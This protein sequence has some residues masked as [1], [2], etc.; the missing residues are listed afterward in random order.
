MA[1]ETMTGPRHPIVHK[2]PRSPLEHEPVQAPAVARWVG[3]GRGPRA[4]RACHD[5]SLCIEAISDRVHESSCRRA[6]TAGS[7]S[8]PTASCSADPAC[9]KPIGQSSRRG[10]IGRI[11]GF[12]PVQRARR[13]SVGRYRLQNATSGYIVISAGGCDAYAVLFRFTLKRVL[14]FAR[15]SRAPGCKSLSEFTAHRRICPCVTNE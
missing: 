8:T 7:R 14:H 15:P 11:D 6:P 4:N 9:H 1:V 2:S 12:R 5:R 3:A 13:T 10:R